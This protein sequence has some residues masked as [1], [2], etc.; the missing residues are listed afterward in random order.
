MAICTRA[1]TSVFPWKPRAISTKSSAMSSEMRL[2]EFGGSCRGLALV[3]PEAAERDDPSVSNPLRLAAAPALRLARNRQPTAVRSR[4][5]CAPTSGSPQLSLR[6]RRLDR[7]D[8]EATQNRFDTTSSR[9]AEEGKINA[10]RSRHISVIYRILPKFGR[11]H[12]FFFLLIGRKLR[13][14][15]GDRWPQLGEAWFEPNTRVSNAC[16]IIFVPLCS[17]GTVVACVSCLRGFLQPFP[18]Y[19]PGAVIREARC[20]PW[21]PP[22]QPAAIIPTA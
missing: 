2:R 10:A 3:E 5:G 20:G 22:S 14:C 7:R 19:H 18:F 6:Q 8:R 11:W 16:R 21:V 15:R 13:G 12:L 9:K 1:A 17:Q 4:T